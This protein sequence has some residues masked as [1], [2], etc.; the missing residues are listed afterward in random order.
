MSTK[1]T[2]RSISV[3]GATYDALR[4]FCDQ[5]GR[6]MS[7]IVEEQIAQ[8]LGAPVVAAAATVKAEKVERPR[9]VKAPVEKRAM[10]NKVVRAPQPELEPVKAS[11]RSPLPGRPAPKPAKEVVPERPRAPKGDYRSIQF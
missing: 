8:V 10:A 5:H 1:Q 3:R 2:R 9:T 11:G 7:E 6:S 4:A